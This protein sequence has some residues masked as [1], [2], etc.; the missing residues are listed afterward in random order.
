MPG[1][2]LR[3][4]FRKKLAAAVWTEQQREILSFPPASTAKHHEARRN[5]FCRPASL[6]RPNLNLTAYRFFE[7]VGGRPP[8]GF[9][10]CDWSVV[11][12]HASTDCPAA[13]LARL[14][15][16]A[17]SADSCRAL[18][19]SSVWAATSSSARAALRRQSEDDTVDI[20]V[21]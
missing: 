1:G 21:M 20:G 8:E 4:R 7:E 12:G 3:R 14:N 19:A 6:L 17:F 5:I 15:L 10:D 2:K 18:A 9:L 11:S 13:R 16:A